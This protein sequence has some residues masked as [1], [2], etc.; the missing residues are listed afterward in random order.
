MDVT[1]C[2]ILDRDLNARQVVEHQIDWVVHLSGVLSATGERNPM[3]A[4]NVNLQGL[5]AVL[6]VAQAH[7]LRVFAPSTIA[8]F[9]P[10]TPVSWRMCLS[11]F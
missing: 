5:H 10:E 1:T 7:D 3:M 9:G 11:L 4:L 6:D 2:V 8:A